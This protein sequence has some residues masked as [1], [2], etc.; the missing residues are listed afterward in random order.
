MKN[1]KTKSMICISN[2]VK[3]GNKKSDSYWIGNKDF[4]KN[5]KVNKV[6]VSA[7]HFLVGT[8]WQFFGLRKSTLRGKHKM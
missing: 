2:L 4:Q 1:P 8:F 6:F 3:E 5:L 7:L